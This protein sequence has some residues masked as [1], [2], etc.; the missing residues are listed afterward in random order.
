MRIG[1]RSGPGSAHVVV[2]EVRVSQ[3]LARRDRHLLHAGNNPELANAAQAPAP[4]GA[5]LR[6]EQQAFAVGKRSGIETAKA[7]RAGLAGLSDGDA[8]GV[9]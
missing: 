3:Q 9:G 4:L 1:A 7:P 5:D 8:F 2:N 6:F